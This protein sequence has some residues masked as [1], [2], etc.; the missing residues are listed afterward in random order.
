VLDVVAGV[1]AT[2]N[3]DAEIS[4]LRTD[5]KMSA[6]RRHLD[7]LVDRAVETLA[8]DRRLGAAGAPGARETARSRRGRSGIVFETA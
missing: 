2:S 8:A 6:R 3:A 5:V 1:H 7:D 4:G